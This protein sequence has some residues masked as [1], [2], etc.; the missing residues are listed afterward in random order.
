MLEQINN[1][2]NWWIPPGMFAGLKDF[3]KVSSVLSSGIIK[4]SGT[5]CQTDFSKSVIDGTV[6]TCKPKCSSHVLHS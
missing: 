3:L 2:G 6:Q 4:N 5:W 1:R